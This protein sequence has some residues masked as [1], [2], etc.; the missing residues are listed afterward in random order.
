MKHLI[1]I[2]MAL[3]KFTPEALHDLLERARHSNTAVGV[4]GCLLYARGNF[5]QMLEGDDDAVDAVF[6]KI[7]LDPRH[8]DIRV[9]NYEDCDMRVFNKWWMAFL[10]L[11][12]VEDIPEA[13]KEKFQACAS[14]INADPVRVHAL[15]TEFRNQLSG[16]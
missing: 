3:Q 8:T 7:T 12:D 4:T 15:F 10:N 1:Y 9:L 13:L 16:E 14:D 2:S 6:N 11:D 5:I